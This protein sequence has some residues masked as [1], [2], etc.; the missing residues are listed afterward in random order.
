MFIHAKSAKE[1]LATAGV[2][3]SL[4]LLL[5]LALML[6]R[7]GGYSLIFSLLFAAI[8][9]TV[10]KGI[11]HGYTAAMCFFSLLA[12]F[13]PAGIINPF[14]C[15]DEEAA[16]HAYAPIAA[17]AVL[18]AAFFLLLFDCLGEHARL[19][20]LNRD[21]WFDPKST[22]TLFKIILGVIVLSTMGLLPA[23]LQ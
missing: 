16:G 15:M 21:S 20:C 22:Q 8:A 13:I 19:R 23:L 14:W 10:F 7:H 3:V 12:I 5:A 9:G 4:C 1:K 18:A 2:L 6:A 17:G 11:K